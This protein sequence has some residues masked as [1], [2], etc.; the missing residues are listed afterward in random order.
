MG[1]TACHGTDA[2]YDSY[3]PPV[4]DA[5]SSGYKLNHAIRCVRNQF[6]FVHWLIELQDFVCFRVKSIHFGY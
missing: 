5:D 1:G 2:V 4:L 6:A 3:L